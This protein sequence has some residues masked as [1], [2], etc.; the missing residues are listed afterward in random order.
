MSLL[1]W[2]L[3]EDTGSGWK[4]KFE[5][6]EVEFDLTKFQRGFVEIGNTPRRRAE[7]ME[8]ID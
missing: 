1:G 4:D 3:A 5:A 7:L 6:L 2:R 8:L